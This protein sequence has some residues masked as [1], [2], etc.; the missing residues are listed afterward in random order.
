MTPSI[1]QGRPGLRSTLRRAGRR[2]RRSP[3]VH[4]GM[5]M[6]RANDPSP[7]AWI[8]GGALLLLA[9]G[10]AVSVVR[11]GNQA[12][13]DDVWARPEPRPTADPTVDAGADD[14]LGGHPS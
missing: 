11:K 13:M 5:S 6:D 7:F 9:V 1:N 10:A 8:F 2:L 12:T 14:M 4:H 3:L